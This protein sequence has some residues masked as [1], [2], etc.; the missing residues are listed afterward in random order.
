VL[1]NHGLAL[2]GG[3]IGSLLIHL[4]IW[5]EIYRLVLFLWR[6]HTV[7]PFLVLLLGAGLI[8]AMVWRKGRGPIR[9][10]RRPIRWGRRRG[11]GADVSG[12]TGYGT[13][14]GPRDW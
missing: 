9:W 10:G 3:G 1:T 7:G 4:F 14:S 8:G 12:S 13:G 5:H 6:I 2:G 11:S